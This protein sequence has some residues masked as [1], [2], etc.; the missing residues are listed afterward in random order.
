MRGPAGLGFDNAPRSAFVVAAIL[1]V[2]VLYSILQI[3]FVRPHLPPDPAPNLA[4]PPATAASG[5]DAL[6]EWRTYY[7]ARLSG[8]RG[9]KGT[10]SAWA[11]AHAG[12]IIQIIV[13]TGAAIVLFLLRS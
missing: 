12:M 8:E 10:P 6:R 7:H 3:G 4:R 9:W 13:F 1:A 11:R 5:G 2:T